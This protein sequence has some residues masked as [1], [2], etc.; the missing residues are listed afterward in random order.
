MDDLFKRRKNVE[1]RCYNFENQTTL[2]GQGGIENQG[3]K[4]HAFD[5]VKN[6]ETKVLLD[7][8]GPGII[9]H[10]W[11]T[12]RNQDAILAPEIL[13]GLWIRIFWE[14]SETP[15]VLA[16]LG[17]FFGI[18]LGRLAD[19]E[20][21]FFSCPCM[22]AFN[23]YIPMPFLQNARMTVTNESGKDIPY[24][25]YTV[26]YRLEPIEKQDIFYF[27]TYWHREQLTKMKEDFEILP[28]IRGEGRYLGAN[29]SVITNKNYR[30]T[31]WGEGE[32]KIYLD[33]DDKYPTIIGTGTEDYPGTAWGLSYF[34]HRFQGCLVEDNEKGEWS[35]YRYH[36]PDP[37][38]FYKHIKVNMQQIGGATKSQL[39][40]IS[41]SGVDIEI[42]SV[43][44]ET[45]VKA[46]DTDPHMTL[47]DERITPDDW[48]NFFRQDDWCATAY[49][50]LDRPERIFA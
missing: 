2:R 34:N 37:I 16:P 19:Y 39:T 36:V 50:Y 6:G 41:N 35:F 8:K 26:N 22:R 1:R 21:E 32:A 7:V 17:D 25:F 4:G 13:Q 11:I 3:A 18:G 23:C 9:D 24:L 29:I 14:N 38:F 5:S 44:K 27:H 42:V 31:W 12:C 49:F 33:G 46:L 15:A 30:D 10:I 28:E 40:E 20:N 47:S 45:F 48:C 43:A